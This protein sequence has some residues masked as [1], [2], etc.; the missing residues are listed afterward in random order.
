MKIYDLKIGNCAS[1]CDPSILLPD[2][3]GRPPI[4]RYTRLGREEKKRLFRLVTPATRPLVRLTRALRG[5]W[6]TR[7]RVKRRRGG[8]WGRWFGFPSSTRPVH[9][10][11]RPGPPLRHFLPRPR[12]PPPLLNFQWE[13]YRKVYRP[14]VWLWKVG[15]P[16]L[17]KTR[18]L[19]VS[20]SK[21][22]SNLSSPEVRPKGS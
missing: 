20:T 9:F 7:S 10:F 8:G 18:P 11:I 3:G 4:E 21:P 2:F 15:G 1:I 13:G 5:T 19:A 12:L 14:S 22:Q 16:R 6:A 17:K